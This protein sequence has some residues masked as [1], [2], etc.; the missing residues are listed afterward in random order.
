[1][2]NI[3]VAT[4][5]CAVRVAPAA[6][7]DYAAIIVTPAQKVL[8]EEA[9]AKAFEAAYRECSLSELIY[10][11]TDAKMRGNVTDEK[12]Q[13][14]LGMAVDA[15]TKALRREEQNNKPTYLAAE[16]AGTKWG[17][18]MEYASALYEATKP[19]RQYSCPSN[20]GLRAVTW[21][22]VHGVY[23]G[24][25]GADFSALEGSPYVEQMKAIGLA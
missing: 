24:V 25:P 15:L 13:R 6:A 8:R 9:F 10:E 23:E 22:W 3:N 4:R 1:M 11:A 14:F 17:G 12:S 19:L 18:L 5:R 7:D 2:M 16:E 20:T 21:A